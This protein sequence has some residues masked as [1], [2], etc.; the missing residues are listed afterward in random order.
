M[1]HDANTTKQELIEATITLLDEVALEEMSAALVLERTGIS[2]SSMYHFFADFSDLL[3]QAFLIRFAASV[4]A[5]DAAI[6]TAVTQSATAKDLFTALE[7][8]TKASQARSNSAVR[9]E[10]ARTLARSEHS[11]RFRASLG[12]LQQNLTDSLTEGITLAQDKGFITKD[13]N[14]HTIAVFIQAY[15]L[16]RIVDDITTNPMNDKDWEKL[17]GKILT[18]TLAQ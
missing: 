13:F 16:G 10:R 17:I 4:R 3:E 15:T 2:K 14:A 5:S 9:F 6:K 12:E 8:I 7:K 18:T 1:K 11:E